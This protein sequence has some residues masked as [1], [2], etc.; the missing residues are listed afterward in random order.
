MLLKEVSSPGILIKSG[1]CTQ[2]KS[3]SPNP[4][5]KSS[6]VEGREE[7]QKRKIENISCLRK[8]RKEIFIF[9]G[10]LFSMNSV[11]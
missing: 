5:L 10:I 9:E 1:Y 8:E 11:W 2:I 4:K 3:T 7:M 6:K